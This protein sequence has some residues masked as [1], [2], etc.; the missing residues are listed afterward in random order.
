VV[1]IWNLKKRFK[2]IFYRSY[3]LWDSRN[4][5]TYRGVME[6]KGDSIPNFKAKDTNGNDFDSQML[7]GQKPL[8]IYFK[9][10]TRMYRAS[11]QFS[12]SILI[13]KIW[14]RK[15]SESVVIVE[16]H[17]K[18]TKQYKLPFI[19]LSDHDKKI[20]RLCVP[21]GMYSVPGLL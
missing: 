20:R 7:I 2:Q 1:V 17:Q 8:V 9:Q 16:S 3:S 10:Y 11:V 12:R 5:V 4:F 18:F 14:V 21:S 13:S 15:L 6:L 19:L